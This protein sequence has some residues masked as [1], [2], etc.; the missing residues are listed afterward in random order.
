MEKHLPP[1]AV[2]GFFSSKSSSTGSETEPRHCSSAALA[3]RRVLSHR[4]GFYS[5]F[6]C[7]CRPVWCE[8][9]SPTLTQTSRPCRLHLL[10]CQG[11]PPPAAGTEQ[12]HSHVQGWLRAVPACRSALQSM[13]SLHGNPEQMISRTCPPV[14]ASV[15]K[16]WSFNHPHL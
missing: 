9:V 14:S 1:A 3:H 13:A 2:K 16:F 5:C 15:P 7:L 12:Q 4:M 11:F 6:P 8:I 10:L